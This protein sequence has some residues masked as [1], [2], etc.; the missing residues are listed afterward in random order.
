MSR[1]ISAI[2]FGVLLVGALLAFGG[3][4]LDQLEEAESAVESHLDYLQRR[5]G[6]EAPDTVAVQRR[7]DELQREKSR[8]LLDR[9]RGKDIYELDDTDLRTAIQVLAEHIAVQEGRIRRLEEAQ[10]VRVIPTENP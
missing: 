6:D 10:Q 9:L 5:L 2:S 4:T 3:T 7:L 1:S 8:L